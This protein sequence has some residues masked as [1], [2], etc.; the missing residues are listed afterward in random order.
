[1]LHEG[2]QLP[3]ASPKGALIES[4][5]LLYDVKYL[6]GPADSEAYRSETSAEVAE[7]TTINQAYEYAKSPLIAH[8]SGGQTR[9]SDLLRT[10]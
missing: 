1:M 2:A 9:T 3:A 4:Q 7:E 5:L 6:N 10:C 8:Q